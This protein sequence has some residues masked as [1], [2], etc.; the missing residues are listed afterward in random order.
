VQECAITEQQSEL[1]VFRAQSGF[2]ARVQ[3]VEY[4]K[5]RL[6]AQMDSDRNQMRELQAKNTELLES[7]AELH[8][9]RAARAV[10][11]WAR[12]FSVEEF[13]SW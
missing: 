5:S 10:D 3:A 12:L 7:L 4:D 13:S 2:A 6:H 9:Q 8:E 11:H 1:T